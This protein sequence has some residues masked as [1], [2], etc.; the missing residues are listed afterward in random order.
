[1]AKNGTIRAMPKAQ[2]R[3][4]WDEYFLKLAATVRDRANCLRATHGALLVKDRRIITTGYNGTPKGVKN[5]LEGGCSRC[6]NRHENRLSEHERKDLCICVHAEENAILQ[7]AFHGAPSAGASLYAT[8]APCLQCAKSIIN[9]GIV[10]VVY[11]DPHKSTL[12][13]DT[14]KKAGVKTQRA[15]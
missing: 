9:A 14:L 6:L 11:T 2:S 8:T 4:S 12:G 1:M 7:S 10:R 5:C 3:P 13:V 15:Q